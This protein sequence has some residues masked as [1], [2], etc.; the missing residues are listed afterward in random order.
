MESRRQM[1][2]DQ[3]SGEDMAYKIADNGQVTDKTVFKD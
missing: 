3:Q 1:K 2:Y